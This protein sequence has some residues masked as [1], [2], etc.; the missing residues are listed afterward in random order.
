VQL[1]PADFGLKTLAQSDPKLLKLW[2]DAV[3]KVAAGDNAYSSL[4][5]KLAK[6]PT[7]NVTANEAAAAWKRVSDEFLQVARKDGYN[8]LEIHHWN[9]E[10]KYFID[11][12]TDPTQLVPVNSESLH[13]YIH[14]LTTSNPGFFGNKSGPTAPL[15]QIPPP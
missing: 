8:I 6:N 13:A 10:N 5:A 7:A 9:F 14:K 11:R 3:A 1:T 2:N 12:L 15:H 4:V